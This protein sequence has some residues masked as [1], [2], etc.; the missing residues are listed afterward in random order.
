[1]NKLKTAWANLC[2]ILWHG[3][4]L[5]ARLILS[6]CSIL[7]GWTL[8]FRSVEHSSL[9]EASYI[10]WASVDDL[11]IVG[12]LFM[13]HGVMSLYSLLLGMENKCYAYFSTALGLLVWTGSSA[14]IIMAQYRSGIWMA[15]VLPHLVMGVVAWW[16]GVRV[17]YGRH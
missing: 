11:R 17:L 4:M 15:V 3:D 8:L 12:T 16:W 14:S 13:I 1:M 10:M 5:G 7:W 9:T 6:G 2:L